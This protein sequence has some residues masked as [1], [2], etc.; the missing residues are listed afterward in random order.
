MRVMR[1]WKAGL[2][3]LPLAVAMSCR[4]DGRLS[5]GK[6]ADVLADLALAEAYAHEEPQLA[7]DSARNALRASVLKKHGVT[8]EQVDESL[9]WYGH[10]LE[11]FSKLYA[12]VDKRLEQREKKLLSTAQNDKKQNGRGKSMWPYSQMVMLSPLS[13]KDAITFSIPAPEMPRGERLTWFMRLSEGMP[14]QMTLGVDYRE[15]GTSYIHRRYSGSCRLE[16]DLQTDS[17]RT[18]SRIYGVMK[19]DQPQ[20]FPLWA[21]SISITS[22]ALN[23]GE[24][25]YYF[26][27]TDYR[28]PRSGRAADKEPR[29]TIQP[30]SESSREVLVAPSQ[31]TPPPHAHPKA[32]ETADGQMALPKGMMNE[33]RPGGNPKI[34]K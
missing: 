28:G 8:Q 29:R 5:E 32:N 21:D 31:P 16:L 2:L 33:Q 19:A 3:I 26:Q 15:G 17:A 18:V 1:M 22:R 4:Q 13:A 6:L 7:T 24:Y 23:S 9:D 14:A 12:R 10:N 20:M 11:K 30:I 25:N 34:M 27:Q